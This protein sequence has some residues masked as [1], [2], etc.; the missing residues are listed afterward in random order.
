MSTT[1]QAFYF[2]STLFWI[3][4]IGLVLAIILLKLNLSGDQFEQWIMGESG[5][6]ELL[7]VVV[8]IPGIVMMCLLL[9]KAKLSVFQTSWVICCVLGWTYFAGE[10]LSWGQHLFGWSTP[11]DLAEINDQQETNLHNISS[12]LDQK[13]RLLLELGLLFGAL[14]CYLKPERIPVRLRPIMPTSVWTVSAWLAIIVKLP[15]RISDWSEWDLPDMF[16]FRLSEFQELMFALSLSLYA[17]VLA[18][19]LLPKNR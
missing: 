11:V 8:L 4:P 16:N 15:E 9:I 5:L 14:L 17:L 2:H 6:I 10:E 3:A 12:W 19:R 1:K 13:P 7:T 18:Q